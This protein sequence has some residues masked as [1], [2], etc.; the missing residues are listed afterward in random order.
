M[1]LVAE[2]GPANCAIAEAAASSEAGMTMSDAN[3]RIYCPNSLGDPA[4]GVEE[5]MEPGSSA[6][7]FA[8]WPG[9]P[10]DGIKCI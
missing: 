4:E 2:G 6:V 9:D 10:A 7:G 5:K 1:G 8:V 3:T